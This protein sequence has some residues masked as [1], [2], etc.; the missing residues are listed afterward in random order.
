MKRQSGGKEVKERLLFH[1]TMGC[2][3]EDICSHNFDWRVCG[4][5][6]NLYGKGM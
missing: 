1:G 2:L 6:G 3:L 4:S 5:N